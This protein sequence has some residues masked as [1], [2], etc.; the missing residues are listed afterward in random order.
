MNEKCFVTV[1]IGETIVKGQF[2]ADKGI[3]LASD[4]VGNLS[5]SEVPVQ[6]DTVGDQNSRQTGEKP[7]TPN[8]LNTLKRNPQWEQRQI[9]ETYHVSSL[10]ELTKEQ[11]SD[12]I[13]ASM[14]RKECERKQK[15]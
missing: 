7:I 15:R 3:K 1:Q 8:Q 11:A 12:A 4:L 6:E 10:E 5:S 13:T 2:P 9:F 14:E